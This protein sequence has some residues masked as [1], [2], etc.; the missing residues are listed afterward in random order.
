MSFP[1]ALL[2]AP[3]WSLAVV[4]WVEWWRHP[5]WTKGDR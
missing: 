3:V 1:V 4:L 2:L 5:R